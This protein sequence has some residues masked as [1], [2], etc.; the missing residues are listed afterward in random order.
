MKY[1]RI[2]IPGGMYFF[3]V[4]TYNRQPI[5]IAPAAVELLR[6]SFRYTMVRHPFTIVASVIL[7]DHL[8]FIWTLPPDSSDFST[9]WRLIKSYFTRHWFSVDYVHDTSSQNLKKEK[10]V[11][12]GR[13]WEHF[14]RD[15]HD[16]T[17]HLDYIHY[18]PVKHGFVDTPMEW[19]YSSFQ[20]Y[21]DDG[22]YPKEWGEDREIWFGEKC[23]E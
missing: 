1:R 14:I 11:W 9:R 13:F 20:N 2:F 23:M 4:V 6:F 5:F 10:N 18:N 3:T 17:R 22:F 12:Q 15:E 7:P 19:K 21:V 16:L 8:H